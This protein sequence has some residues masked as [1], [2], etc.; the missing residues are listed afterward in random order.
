MLGAVPGLVA[1]A[2]VTVAV[3][4]LALL[5]LLAVDMV[6]VVQAYPLVITVDLVAA[7][8]LTLVGVYIPVADHLALLALLGQERAIPLQLLHLKA[9]AVLRLVQL[10]LAPLFIAVAV[11]VLQQ[12]P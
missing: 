8:D 9:L 3:Q 2:V 11:A 5:P 4:L 10:F 7:E 1:Q 6:V 12:Q